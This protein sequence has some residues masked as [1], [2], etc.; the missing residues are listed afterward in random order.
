MRVFLATLIV[1]VCALASPASAHPY[2]HHPVHPM[3]TVLGDGFIHMLRS[4]PRAHVVHERHRVAHRR[5]GHRYAVHRMRKF[6]QPQMAGVMMPFEPDAPFSFAFGAAQ[7]AIDT[8]VTVVGV[9]TSIVAHATV[10][11]AVGVYAASSAVVDQV[12]QAAAAAGVPESIALAVAR[13]ES[14]FNEN[15]R[16]RAGEIGDMQVLPRTARAMGCNNLRDHSCVRAAG[17]RYLALALQQP[18]SMC[19]KLSAYNHGLGYRSCTSYG[20]NIERLAGI[21]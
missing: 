8:S 14:S 9:G 11:A 18:G 3:V 16:G 19:E 21:R 2:R 10:S 5:G 6:A 17:M 15:E 12:R 4:M 13:F 7:D 1:C 20:R